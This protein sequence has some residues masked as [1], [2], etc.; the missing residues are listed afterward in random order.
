[1]RKLQKLVVFC[2]LFLIPAILMASP[3]DIT[4]PEVG[5]VLIIQQTETGDYNAVKFPKKNILHKRTGLSNYSRVEG[6]KVEIVEVTENS[7]GETMVRLK[8]I[9]KNKFFRYWKTVNANYQK[10][11]ENKELR[12]L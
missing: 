10:A 11:I 5:D 9:Q 8:P 6:M 3:C 2:F 4:E 1:M 7:N 12:K